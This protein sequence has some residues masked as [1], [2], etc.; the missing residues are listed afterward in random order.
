MFV[1]DERSDGSNDWNTI[2]RKK[3]IKLQYLVKFLVFYSVFQA[4]E[5]PQ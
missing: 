4:A 5:L 1:H 2:L 3:N